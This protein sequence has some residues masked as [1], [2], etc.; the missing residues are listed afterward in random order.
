MP[1][2]GLSGIFP[3]L[4][5]PFT[6]GGATVDG[7]A[8]RDLVERSI[9]AGVD[10]L[11]PCGGTGEFASLTVAERKQ[12]VGIVS[13]SA[14]GRVPVVASAGGLSAA[15][16][17]DHC[18]DAAEAGAA[19][20]MIGVPFY[21]PCSEDQVLSYFRT[22]S[23]AVDLPLMFYNYPYATGF[24]L[25]P[26]F[27]RHLSESVPSLRYV[28]DSSGDFAAFTAL[29]AA[30]PNIG[31]FCGSDTLSGPA[32]LAGAVGLI[33]GCANF[34]PEP[35]VRMTKALRS[36]DPAT[37]ID[38][39]QRLLPVLSFIE[40]HPFVSG[41]KHALALSGLD[42]G[43]VRSPLAELSK[44]EVDQLSGLLGRWR[45]SLDQGPGRS[46]NDKDRQRGS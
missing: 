9:D 29:A 39:W 25:T 8:L 7:G 11:L 2:D 41:V 18:Q 13:E 15:E 10:G 36:D 20:L 33:N 21:E 4:T 40:S 44:D 37:L 5:T 38:E 26:E 19:A 12:V 17:I 28:K 45:A 34:A 14:A 35:F 27:L 32:Y 46:S 24:H 16:A 42:V 30:N 6:A 43:A 22:I 31:I 23:S 3:A 1:D